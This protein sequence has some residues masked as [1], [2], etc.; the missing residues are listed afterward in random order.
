MK[1]FDFPKCFDELALTPAHLKGM[2]FEVIRRWVE[3][4]IG[5][6]MNEDEPDDIL[7]NFVMS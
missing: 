1:T 6:I 4:R 7:V 2:K 5:Q 3:R